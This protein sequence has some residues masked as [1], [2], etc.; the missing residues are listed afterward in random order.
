V[1]AKNASEARVLRTVFYR[2]ERAL[3][4]RRHEVR[5]AGASRIGAGEIWVIG[6]GE[7]RDA[8]PGSTIDVEDVETRLPD[9]AALGRLLL[10]V[11]GIGAWSELDAYL[12]GLKRGTG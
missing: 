10:R 6:N 2:V 7:I 5:H 11:L 1:L 3:R 4:S 12:A 9:E 8:D